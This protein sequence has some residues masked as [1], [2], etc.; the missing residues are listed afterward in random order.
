MVKGFIC[1][2]VSF[3]V[4][5]KAFAANSPIHTDNS[6]LPRRPDIGNNL[7]FNVS[8]CDSLYLLSHRRPQVR[9]GVS[10]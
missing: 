5:Y 6:E 9:S 3:K 8:T 10:K 7:G 2:E 1:I 4:L